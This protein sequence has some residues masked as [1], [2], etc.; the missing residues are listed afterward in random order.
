MVSQEAFLEH[1]RDALNHIHDPDRLGRSPLASLFGVE[2]RLS[3]YG[4]LQDILT[5]AITAMRPGRQ[6]PPSSR[7][8][9]IYELLVCRYLQEMSATQVAHQLG[10]SIRHLHRE[11]AAALDALGQHLWNEI[12]FP[13][14]G[15]PPGHVDADAPA[16][17]ESTSLEDELTWLRGDLQEGP[18]ELRQ[19]LAA[20]VELAAPL[21]ER[22]GVGIRSQT[23]D[24]IPMLAVHPVGLKQVLLSLAA[25]AVH[26]ANGGLV[27]ISVRP[28]GWNVT[29]EL[30]CPASAPME[31]VMDAEGALA[32]RSSIDGAADLAR[33]CGMRLW[34][35]EPCDPFAV[36][37]VAPAL[38]GALVLA[39]DDNEDAL[40]LLD[41]YLAGT[42]YRLMAESDPERAM[43]A[44]TSLRPA[45]VVL[46]VMMPQVDGWRVLGRLRSHP[47]TS[48]IPVIVCTILAQEEL[49]LSLGAAAC[50]RKPVTQQRFL[51]TLD[52]VLD[53]EGPESR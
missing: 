29:I 4:E 31:A 27:L 42:R 9:R 18:T 30:S 15:S 37:L 26:A 5:S 22:H 1:L 46:D 52:L 51:R 28:A 25:T 33:L 3:A 20:A 34:T 53:Q 36:Q 47:A 49:A 24:S 6:V 12:P 39:V 19:V 32:L 45:A 10:L 41:R 38:Q 13:R 44:A 8:W 43:D 11:Q 14:A 50:L 23:P 2:G 7:A 16:E 48:R 21:A 40:K 17:P 35:S